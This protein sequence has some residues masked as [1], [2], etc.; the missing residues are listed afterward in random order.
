MI[1][2]GE[3][4]RVIVLIMVKRGSVKFSLVFVWWRYSFELLLVGNKVSEVE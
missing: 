4:G 3:R 1:S 2:W